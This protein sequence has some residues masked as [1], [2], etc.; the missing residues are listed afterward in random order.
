MRVEVHRRYDETFK[1]DA[2][3]LLKRS[4]RSMLR[5][6]EDLGIGVS[7]LRYWYKADMAQ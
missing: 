3:E 5:V 2:L 1:R 4:D 7:T 6:A